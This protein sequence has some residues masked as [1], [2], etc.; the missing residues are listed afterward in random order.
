MNGVGRHSASG[1]SEA[2]QEYS[3]WTLRFHSPNLEDAF[4]RSRHPK[5]LKNSSYIAMLFVICSAPDL[6]LYSQRLA[7]DQVGELGRLMF[8]ALAGVASV[9]LAVSLLTRLQCV[10]RCVGIRCCECLW[11][12]LIVSVLVCAMFVAIRSMEK[13]QCIV[14][15][16]IPLGGPKA[17]SLADCQC[18]IAR[19]IEGFESQYPYYSTCSS[20]LYSVLATKFGVALWLDGLVT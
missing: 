1:S 15:D 9:C 10:K 3:K 11:I 13:R 19:E 6:F 17:K 5:M 16:L 2:S 8:I 12:A 4:L 7:K 18:S 20:C 14:K